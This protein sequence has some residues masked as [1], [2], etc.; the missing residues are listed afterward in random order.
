MRRLL[1]SALARVG[2]WVGLRGENHEPDELH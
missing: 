2:R 1:L